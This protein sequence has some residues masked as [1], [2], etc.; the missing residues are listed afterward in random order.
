[1]LHKT[2][3][4][5]KALIENMVSNDYEVQNE[6]NQLQKKGVLDL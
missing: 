2:H 3:T 5:A 1:M 4:K 6:C